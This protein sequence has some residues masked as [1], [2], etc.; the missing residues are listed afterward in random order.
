MNR[1]LSG[2]GD[3][4]QRS[5]V[6]KRY[7]A[8]TNHRQV[9][10]TQH[11]C[12]PKSGIIH[13]LSQEWAEAERKKQESLIEEEKVVRRERFERARTPNRSKEKDGSSTENKV[14]LPTLTM[15]EK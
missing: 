3:Q 15:R 11:D 13:R 9:R 14:T 5:A 7:V 1:R 4:Q 12:L 6:L 10:L 2:A 8:L